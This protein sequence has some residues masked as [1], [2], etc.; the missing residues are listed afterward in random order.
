MRPKRERLTRD[1]SLIGAAGVHY[2]VSELCLR[3]LIAL[4][5]IRN[6]AGVDVVVVNKEGSWHTDIQ[7]KTSRSKVT[8]WPVGTGYELWQGA[9]RYYVFLRFDTKAGRFDAFLERA[10]KV[11]E[12]TA[13]GLEADKTH[14]RTLWPAFRLEDQADRLRGQWEQFGPD[15]VL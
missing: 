7:V 15:V 1:K 4:P 5:T 2:V 11:I 8:S 10:D 13:I 6:T 3:G 9:N 14:G 12:N